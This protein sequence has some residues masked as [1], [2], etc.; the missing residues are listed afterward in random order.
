VEGLDPEE[1][2]SLVEQVQT[3]TAVEA[4]LD[5]APQS[6]EERI[7]AQQQAILR[8][9]DEH[10]REVQRFVDEFV[11]TGGGETRRRRNHRRR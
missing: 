9:R 10:V 1:I 8:R 5:V 7:I 2:V 3:R 6:D 11:R 4:A